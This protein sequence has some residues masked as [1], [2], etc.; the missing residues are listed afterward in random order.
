MKQGEKGFSYVELIVAI[1][2]IALISG[3]A[4]IAIFQVLKG[5]EHNNNYVTAVRQV[6][7][8]GYWISQ[9][10]QMAQSATAD[11][12]TPPDFLILRW[13]NLDDP[14]NPV[15]HSATY[16]FEDLIDGIGTLKRGHWSSAG[17]NEQTLVAQYIYFDP[18]DPNETSNASY[19]SPLLTVQLTAL[20]KDDKETREYK[21]NHRPN[22]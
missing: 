16:F 4:A 12:L 6:Q 18:D 13:T 15:Y 11:N 2:I 3:A 9:D 8:A 21:I 5:T 1:A 14:D 20:I 17:A 10:M 22:F 7:N 19:Q